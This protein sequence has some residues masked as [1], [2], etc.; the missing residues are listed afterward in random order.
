MKKL[1]V[2]SLICLMM[3]SCSQKENPLL[4]EFN[5][6]FGVPPFEFVPKHKGLIP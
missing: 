4:G 3:I 2:T 6:P 5:T 1:L